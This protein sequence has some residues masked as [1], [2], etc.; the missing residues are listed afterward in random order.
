MGAIQI[1]V[2]CMLLQ[3]ALDVYH[4]AKHVKKGEYLEAVCSAILGGA[5]LHAAIP[6]CKL[7]A[8]TL[9]HGG[10]EFT[11]ELKQNAQGF[12]YLDVPDEYVYE[13]FAILGETGAQVTSLFWK[14][15]CRCPCQ[16]DSWKSK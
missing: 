10:A 8:W 5:H 4:F 15:R 14:R 1:T 9:K 12:V 6:Q 13:L 3:V 7:L 11:A 2:A 16:C